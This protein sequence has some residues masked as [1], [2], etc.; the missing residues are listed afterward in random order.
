MANPTPLFDVDASQ[1]LAKLHLAG[2]EPVTLNAN[3][4]IVNTAIK[5]DN[6]KANPNNPG[7][8]TFDLSNPSGEYCVGFV[9]EIKYSDKK[10]GEN[11]GVLED[12]ARIQHVIQSSS[13]STDDPINKKIDEK[14]A[15][16]LDAAKEEL[17]KI[18][19]DNKSVFDQ[20]LKTIEKEKIDINDSQTITPDN[21]GKLHDVVKNAFK[22]SSPDA[23]DN[24]KTPR[25]I[26]IDKASINAISQ[27]KTYMVNFAG[28]DKGDKITAD[29][30]AVLPISNSMV[31]SNSSGLITSTF[32]IAERLEAETEKLRAAA[33][34]GELVVEKIC[35][36]TMYGIELNR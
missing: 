6:P 14:K 13:N 12:L 4:F 16:E 20:A 32:R 17:K 25:A 21:I 33:Q 11:Q 7:K 22:Q 24:E 31:D 30:C 29:N 28:P 18:Y 1:I 36:A 34:A 5:N 2:L 9:T 19:A 27:L 23:K 8:V 3:Q 35:F 26:E 10:Q 15:K